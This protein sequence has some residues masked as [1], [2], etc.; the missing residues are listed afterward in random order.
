MVI[1]YHDWLGGPGAYNTSSMVH[2]DKMDLKPKFFSMMPAVASYSEGK[3]D[4]AAGKVLNF[5]A[6]ELDDARGVFV[7]FAL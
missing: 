7:L 4:R 5:S 6:V 2:H 1:G 3:D